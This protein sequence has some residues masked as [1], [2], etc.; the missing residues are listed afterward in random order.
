M[1]AAI[2]KMGRLVNCRN[3]AFQSGTCGSDARFVLPSHVTHVRDE[4]SFNNAKI[5]IEISS[6]QDRFDR[7]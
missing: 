6:A 7:F 3:P 1:P 2:A 4:L 5:I